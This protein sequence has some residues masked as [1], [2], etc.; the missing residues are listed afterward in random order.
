MFLHIRIDIAVKVSCKI[1]VVGPTDV[2]AYEW[3]IY[4]L[5]EANEM[6]KGMPLLESFKIVFMPSCH[7]EVQCTMVEYTVE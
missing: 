6:F 7:T 3:N 5:L 4:K 2:R 1:A